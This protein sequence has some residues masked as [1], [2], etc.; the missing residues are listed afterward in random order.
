MD[1]KLMQSKSTSR[2]LSLFEKDMSSCIRR[3]VGHATFRPAL[4]LEIDCDLR[5]ASFSFRNQ[6]K[7]MRL[8]D[9][10]D[11]PRTTQHMMSTLKTMFT[12]VWN[13]HGVAHAGNATPHVTKRVKSCLED[14]NVTTGLHPPC[15][16]ERAPTAFS[17]SVM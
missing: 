8:S 2:A 6:H 9:N 16:S 14:H 7:Q 4:W 1:D 10:G 12:L 15:G 17:S 3:S 13:L 5:Y 11:S